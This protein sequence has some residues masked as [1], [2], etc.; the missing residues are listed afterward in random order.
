MTSPSLTRLVESRAGGRCEYCRMHQ[1][2]QGATFHIEHVIPKARGGSDEADNRALACPSCNLKKSDLISSTD[3]ETG[4]AV[5]LFNPRQD[6]WEEHFRWEGYCIVGQSAIGRA[7]IA[8][9]D[10]NSPRRQLIR[11]AEEHFGLFPA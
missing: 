2:L 8:L 4:M 10:L 3:P 9:F 11:E 7:L 6:V 5:P 1:A